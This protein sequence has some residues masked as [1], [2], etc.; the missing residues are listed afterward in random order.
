[1]IRLSFTWVKWFQIALIT[2]RHEFDNY[3]LNA[4][5]A[6]LVGRLHHRVPNIGANLKWWHLLWLKKSYFDKKSSK[7]FNKHIFRF[8]SFVA[9]FVG[10][11]WLSPKITYRFFTDPVPYVDRTAVG[12]KEQN[13]AK[14]NSKKC[15]NEKSFCMVLINKT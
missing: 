14:Q 11:S 7:L 10:F 3:V 9:C 8:V 6:Y 5:F 2:Y 15:S 13:E 12:H 4:G 1:M